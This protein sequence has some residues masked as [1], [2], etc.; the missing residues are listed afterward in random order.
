MIQVCRIT[1][2]SNTSKKILFVWAYQ[3]LIGEAFLLSRLYNECCFISLRHLTICLST[4]LLGSNDSI[5]SG[6]GAA[7]ATPWCFSFSVILL[8]ICCC[9]WTPRHAASPSLCQPLAVAQTSSQLTLEYFDTQT[10]TKLQNKPKS[11]PIPH[12]AWQYHSMVGCYQLCYGLWADIS[13]LALSLFHK[14]L[15]CSDSDFAN[16]N[17]VAMTFFQ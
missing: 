16:L 2:G 13:T 7:T 9:V 15:F 12:H 10:S 17:Y 4:A 6:W 3:S 8:Q 5:E 11:S 1:F 14:S